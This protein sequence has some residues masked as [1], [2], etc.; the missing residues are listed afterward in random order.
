MG[1]ASSETSYN[2]LTLTELDILVEILFSS[3]PFSPDHSIPTQRECQSVQRFLSRHDVIGCTWGTHGHQWRTRSLLSRCFRFIWRKLSK[4][5]RGEKER[6]GPDAQSGSQLISSAHDSH[7]E[8]PVPSFPTLS[9]SPLL[10]IRLYFLF[11]LVCL[12]PKLH[13]IRGKVLSLSLFPRIPAL[14]WL[15][16]AGCIKS[17]A[18]AGGAL[19]VPARPSPCRCGVEWQFCVGTPVHALC[20]LRLQAPPLPS[21]GPG[22][23]W[24]PSQGGSGIP[25]TSR[26]TRGNKQSK[27]RRACRWAMVQW[28]K[29]Q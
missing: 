5:R 3:A 22:G 14:C 10:P 20:R 6:E 27:G 9:E 29:S 8:V 4:S 12:E 28:V 1:E 24:G 15:F 13:W 25:V 16:K 18:L 21:W 26:E 19:T 7:P 23:K 11:F 17:G 2:F